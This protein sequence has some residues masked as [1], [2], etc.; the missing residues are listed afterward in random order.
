MR[1]P[2]SAA[3]SAVSAS[4][5]VVA[6]SAPASAAPPWT[7]SPGGPVAGYANLPLL[8]NTTRGV[9]LRCGSSRMTAN[10]DVGSS[11][12]NLLGTI[13]SFV[14]ST[15]SLAGI[16][17]YTYQAL[18]LPWNLN[19][20]PSTSTASVMRGTITGIRIQL[21]GAGCAALLAG[22]SATTPGQLD[23][24]F[25]NATGVLATSGGNLRVWNVN[26]CWG[27][28]VTGDAVTLQMNYDP[29]LPGQNI[30]P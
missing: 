1:K 24:T 17:P 18:N 4:A 11:S 30:T 9:T 10:L 16:Y 14:M 6:V 23:V 25:T 5:F 7:I 22:S 8:V 27:L 20:N 13:T 3:L 26:G 15:C 21:S 2:F 29:F 28:L 19:G 12:D